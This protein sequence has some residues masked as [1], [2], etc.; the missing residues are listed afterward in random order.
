MIYIGTGYIERYDGQ[1]F[2]WLGISPDIRVEQT[3]KDIQN[4]RDKQLEYAIN[5]LK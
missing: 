2:E 5:M 3:E 4:G 1:P